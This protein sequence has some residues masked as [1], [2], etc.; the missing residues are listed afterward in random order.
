MPADEGRNISGIAQ[1]RGSEG[2]G[3]Y[4]HAAGLARQLLPGGGAAG[5]GLNGLLTAS[6]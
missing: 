4:A 2:H 6:P 3:C 5:A 1:D